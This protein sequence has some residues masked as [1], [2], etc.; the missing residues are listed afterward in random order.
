[1]QNRQKKK[2][3]IEGQG[4]RTK[5]ENRHWGNQDRNNI[6]IERGRKKKNYRQKNK[7]R[8][9]KRKSTESKDRQTTKQNGKLEDRRI[10]E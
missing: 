3:Q 5:K 2:S 10:E 8:T 1:M 9:R 6:R 4:K 7:Q